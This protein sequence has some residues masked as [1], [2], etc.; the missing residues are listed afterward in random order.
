MA[1]FREFLAAFASPAMDYQSGEAITHQPAGVE[2]DAVSVTA[3]IEEMDPKRVTQSGIEADR[4]LVLSMD[5]AIDVT[6]SDTWVY[7][8]VTY[9]THTYSNAIDGRR[10]VTIK[11]V[12]ST[13][14]KGH[15]RGF[16]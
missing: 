16:I 14:R 10:T 4:V 7:G 2:D 15:G 11:H 13:Q 6:M 1:L 3:T 12:S 9:A 8:G 5:P